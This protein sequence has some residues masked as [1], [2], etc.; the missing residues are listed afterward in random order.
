MVYRRVLPRGVGSGLSYRAVK[1]ARGVLRGL[2][3][4]N[5]PW[6][7]DRSLSEVPIEE[8][9]RENLYIY[10]IGDIYALLHFRFCRTGL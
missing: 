3:A 6:L 9:Y 10:E 4:S 1:V 8:D 5:G 7:P 2:G